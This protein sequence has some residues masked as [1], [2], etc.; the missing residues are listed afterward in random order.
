[1]QKLALVSCVSVKGKYKTEA[2]YLYMSTWFNKAKA[3]VLKNYDI[4]AILSAKYG[5][6]LPET[7]IAPYNQTLNTY[8]KNKRI[9]WAKRVNEQL[10]TAYPAKNT[11]IYLFAGYKYRE[12]LVPMLK[13]GG[14]IVDI[15]LERM[16]IGQQLQWFTLQ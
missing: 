2:Q 9:E 5:L 6:L 3:Y 13:K 16:Q 11:S 12:F 15:P 10:Y 1:M 7:T 4:W 8:L 14:Y